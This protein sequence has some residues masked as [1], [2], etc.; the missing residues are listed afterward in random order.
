M[1]RRLIEK[2]FGGQRAARQGRA[3]GHWRVHAAA[4]HRIDRGDISRA[5]IQTCEGLQ[6]AGYDAY[7]VGGAVRDLLLGRH[8]KDFDVATNAT[9]EQVRGVFRRARII[10]RRFRIVHVMFRD[11][12]IEVSTYRSSHANAGADGGGPA[13]EHQARADEHGRLTRDNVFGTRE[14][15]AVRRDF[16]MNALYYNPHDETVHDFVGGL[17]DIRKK[18]VV[19]IGDAATRYR[20][21]PVRM[22]RAARLA[23]KLEFAIE[24]ATEKPIPAM[25][26]LLENV[27]TAR[28]YDEMLKLLLSGHALAGLSNMV[29]LGLHRNLIPV[30]ET[31]TA[32]R[33]EA[34]FVRLALERTDERIAADKGVSPAFLF[35]AL[36]WHLV[37]AKIAALEAR[38]L[39]T[40]QA[41]HEAMDAVL[42]QQR[43][44]LAIPRRLDPNIK[45]IWISQPRFLQRGPNRAYRTLGM[46][47][48]RACY[49]FFALRS[50]VGDA[51][52][53]IAQWWERF[54]FAD[55]AERAEMCVADEDP[56]RKKRKRRRRKPA[57]VGG[58]GEGGSD[59]GQDAGHASSDAEPGQGA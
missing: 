4:E 17:S 53:D 29:R 30:A 1:I 45:E 49:D 36:F 19:M 43:A 14:E 9:P 40:P 55:E 32:D 58:G 34:K 51:D 52:P 44:T 47:R 56:S 15:D 25:L 31:L 22:L 57:P 10:G 46:E 11:E 35:A 24:P 27:P 39:R 33:T 8:P 7:I 20:E 41:W 16:T 42:D 2:V 23:A 18:R 26:A 6:A 12:T 48:F 13:E 38:G 54:Q 21:D 50:E 5:A 3:E 59:A 28:L 37:Q